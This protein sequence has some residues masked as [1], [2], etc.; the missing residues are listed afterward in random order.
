MLL[1]LGGLNKLPKTH[2]HT[3]SIKHS[4]M[5]L[6]LEGLDPTDHKTSL[7]L[8]KKKTKHTPPHTPKKQKQITNTRRKI[9]FSEPATP[10]N[11]Y[12]LTSPV[13]ET[14]PI[15]L[16]P[17]PKT[18][19]TVPGSPKPYNPVSPPPPTPQNHQV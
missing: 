9:N 15:L 12:V 2:R 13:P 5:L 19:S 17:N 4:P 8:R 11:T 1:Q 3:P 6:Q 14:R 10:T 16:T 18:S 7:N